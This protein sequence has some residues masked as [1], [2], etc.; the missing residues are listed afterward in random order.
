[1]HDVGVERPRALVVDDDP[2][3]R[4]T[5]A[6]EL[7][8]CFEVLDADHVT[9]A[10]ARFATDAIDV[11]V[12]DLELGAGPS[13]IELLAEVRQRHPGCARILVSAIMDPRA[14]QQSVRDQISHVFIEKPWRL[15]EVRSAACRLAGLEA[16]SPPT[17]RTVEHRRFARHPKRLRAIYELLETPPEQCSHASAT[18]NI[19][20]A[21]CAL[22][23]GDRAV[24]P[25]IDLGMCL[26]MPAPVETRVHLHG[27]IVWSRVPTYTPT[28]MLID[29]GVIGVEL[30]V[31]RNLPAAYEDLLEACARDGGASKR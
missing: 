29:P 9:A 10:L 31:G 21:G 3:I 13:G 6:R 1:V 28:G 17:R 5:L 19:S 8:P 27:T 16:A 12:T 24:R 30:E 14:A 23:T 26:F 4:R 11:V 15:G 25:R 7:R 2:L 18:L 22:L 20:Q